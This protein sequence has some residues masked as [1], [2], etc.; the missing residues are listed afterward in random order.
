MILAK[1]RLL[2]AQQSL[3]TLPITGIT[4]SSTNFDL[5]Q[6]SGINAPPPS[7]VSSFVKLPDL[8]IMSKLQD[9]VFEEKV[10]FSSDGDSEESEGVMFDDD[11]AVDVDVLC[12]KDD[13]GL[14]MKFDR[15]VLAYDPDDYGSE[16]Q[17]F[18]DPIYDGGITITKKIK[19]QEKSL[20]RDSWD[21]FVEINGYD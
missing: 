10:V 19:G 11:Y 5:Q 4:S 14:I 15:N 9:Y 13:D 1:N 8:D 3:V 20:V 2:T 18:P 6:E 7:R 16:L 21:D 12:V 17:L